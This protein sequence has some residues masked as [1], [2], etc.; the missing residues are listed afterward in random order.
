MQRLHT[1]ID[2]FADTK[3]RKHWIGCVILFAALSAWQAATWWYAHGWF[4]EL[5]LY[6]GLLLLSIS[7]LVQQR[8]LRLAF[9]FASIPLF[10]VWLALFVRLPVT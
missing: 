9:F 7:L 2:R 1:R 10:A 6:T 3:S 5:A 8:K 4:G